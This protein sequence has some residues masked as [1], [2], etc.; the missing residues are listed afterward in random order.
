[1]GCYWQL[2]GETIA[3]VKMKLEE[4]KSLGELGWTTEMMSRDEINLVL[5]HMPKLIAVVDA[6]WLKEKSGHNDT[7]GVLLVDN[8]EYNYPCSCGYKEL[9]A[10]LKDLEKE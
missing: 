2:S 4:L 8:G 7:C 3:G 5:S 6:A 9:Y 10:A 1:M